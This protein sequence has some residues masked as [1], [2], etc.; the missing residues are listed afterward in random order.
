MVHET[1]VT[2]TAGAHPLIT[3]PRRITIIVA[4]KSV[5]AVEM[6]R[7]KEGAAKAKHDR[8][9]PKDRIIGVVAWIRRIVRIDRVGANGIRIHVARI[10]VAWIWEYLPAA[11]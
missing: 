8:R 6:I 4:M 3:G 9:I 7:E 1:A 11:I 5:E 10:P 2:K